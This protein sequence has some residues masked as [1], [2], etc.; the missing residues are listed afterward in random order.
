M[1][2]THNVKQTN[3]LSVGSKCSMDLAY[4]QISMMNLM[5]GFVHGMIIVV[6]R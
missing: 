3:D 4:R 2:Y 1:A 5:Y 6:C